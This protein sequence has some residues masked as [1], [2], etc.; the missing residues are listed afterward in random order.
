VTAIQIQTTQAKKIMNRPED[1]QEWIISCGDESH[2]L[3]SIP[4]EVTRASSYRPSGGWPRLS[5]VHVRTRHPS[6]MIARKTM[7]GARSLVT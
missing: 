2:S 1:L 5:P 3:S 4:V 6:R 7:G